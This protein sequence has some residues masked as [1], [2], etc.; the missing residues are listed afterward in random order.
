MLCP[1]Y[2]GGGKGGLCVRHGSKK[3]ACTTPGCNK[4]AVNGGVCI[5][6][7]AKRPCMIVGCVR[8]LF[9]EKKCRYHYRCSLGDFGSDWDPSITRVMG[10]VGFEV[11]AYLGMTKHNGEISVDCRWDDVFAIT[12]VCQSWREASIDYLNWIKLK[13]GLMPSQGFSEKK[14]NVDGFLSY[15]AEDDRFRSVT[16]FYVPCG[17]VDKLFYGDVKAICPA[18]TKLIHRTW[19]MVNGNVE[20]VREGKGRHQCYWVYKHDKQYI[21]GKQL[22]LNMPGMESIKRSRSNSWCN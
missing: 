4:N 12:G 17:R 13:I 1:T 14:L 10:M 9:K 18:M 16:T 19:L 15:L 6:H 3:K 21:E 20:Y 11:L 5:A 2:L 8:N 7:G 22:G